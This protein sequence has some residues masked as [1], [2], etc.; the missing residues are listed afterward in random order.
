MRPPAP[1]IRI[2]RTGLL[3]LAALA[4]AG[5]ATVP[6][7]ARDIKPL[8]ESTCW[9]C[10]GAEK[11]KGGLRLD[12][13]AQAMAGGSNGVAIV[14]GDSAH[15]YLMARLRG[16]GDEKRMPEKAA[17]FSAAQI[18]IV[19]A[20]I[21]A[22]APWP[23]SAAD[24]KA[25]TVVHWSYVPPVRPIPPS[26]RAAVWVRNPIDAFVAAR[27]EREQLPPTTEAAPATLIRRVFLDLIGLPPTPA[28]VEAF[29]AD[30]A[31]DAYE[32]V[33]DRLL[34][35][36]HYGER[37]ARP[38]LDLA[39]YADTDGF[40]FD[41]PRMVWPYR[42]WVIAALNADM[43]FDRF[44]IAQLAGDLLPGATQADRVATGFHRNTMH[45]TEGG[46]DPEE[47]RWETEIDRTNTTAAVWLGSTFACAQCH[48]HKYDPISQK[49][50]YGLLAFFDNTNEPTLPLGG[51]VDDYNG[52]KKPLSALVMAER[53]GPAQTN[54]RVRGAYVAKGEVVSAGTPGFLPPMPADSPRNRLGLARWLVDRGNPLTARVQVNR[55]WEVLFGHGLVETVE[56]F[57]NQGTAPSHPELLDWLAVE[58]M[59]GKWS[60]KRLQRLIVT[61]A[62]YR[63]SSVV[64]P[65]HLERDPSNHLLARGAR[66]RLEAEV[67]RDNA[68]AVSGLLT[69]AV[70]GPSVFPPAPSEV[71]AINTNKESLPW[72]TSAGDDRHRRALYTFCR[73]TAP[74]AAF[75]NF[76][77]PSRE[78]CLL[79]RARTDTPLQALT[80]LNDPAQ[81]E[82]A[83]ALGR[84]MVDQGSVV[85]ER[86]AM[87]FRLCTARAPTA[88]EQ[89]DLEAA[90]AHEL[91]AFAK[92]PAAA[93]K[94]CGGAGAADLAACTM[95]ANALLNLDET[96]TRE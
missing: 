84:R 57:G 11:Q 6:D 77:A 39:R 96:M 78:A 2:I 38:W 25:A 46:V 94:V 45:N 90:Y 73:R 47:A 55:T 22:G 79:R 3:L 69:A 67:I 93:A 13:R 92:T 50:Y 4:A 65:G 89:R 87:G 26:V 54:L 80:G 52:K 88:D 66:F 56:D 91:A 71:G 75:T 7:Y 30:R 70:G 63:Q 35:S 48:N 1:L 17:A 76:D 53:A 5:A 33:V 59:E 27:L 10:H 23:E 62:T 19:A 74:Y 8:F 49:D 61:S 32:R 95:L 85:S 41:L 16:E 51:E 12:V 43:P 42:D 18:G 36:P 58:L 31:P 60:M 28:E 44:T 24:A 37:W 9:K 34:A 72:R 20:W 40:N 83:Q 64:D 21:D 14:A 15:S 86:V 82:A 81:W 68:L 29:L